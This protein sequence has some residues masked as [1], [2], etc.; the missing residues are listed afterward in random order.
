[1]F[2]WLSVLAAI[3]LFGAIVVLLLPNRP[4]VPSKQVALGFSLLT[5]VVAVAAATQ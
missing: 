2:P 4:T 5:L 3:P 1:M